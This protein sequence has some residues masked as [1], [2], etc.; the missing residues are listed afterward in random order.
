M[1]TAERSVQDVVEPNGTMEVKVFL[2]HS[3]DLTPAIIGDCRDKF[4]IQSTPVPADWVWHSALQH[5]SQVHCNRHCF[6]RN[7]SK[8]RAMW[9]PGM[10]SPPKTL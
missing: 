2:Q 9:W 6:V 1:F 7:E 5:P 4:L 8:H 10:C 3:K